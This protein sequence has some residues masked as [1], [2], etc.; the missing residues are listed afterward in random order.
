[1]EYVPGGNLKQFIE[2]RKSIN[3]H[4]TEEEIAIIMKSLLSAIKC[5][6]QNQIIHRDLKPGNY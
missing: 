5:M 4:F 6:H 1:M 3:K 2:Y